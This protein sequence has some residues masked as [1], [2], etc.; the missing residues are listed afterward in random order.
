MN[1]KKEMFESNV[2]TVHTT[3]YKFKIKILSIEPSTHLDPYKFTFATGHIYNVQS[4]S[5]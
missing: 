1:Y 4:Y 5:P 3:N 2:N